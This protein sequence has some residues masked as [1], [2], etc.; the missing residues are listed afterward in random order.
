M[1]TER[2]QKVNFGQEGVNFLI[3]PL[4]SPA[5]SYVAPTSRVRMMPTDE[6]SRG[7][8]AQGLSQEIV[9]G[10]MAMQVSLK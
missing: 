3:D 4:L 9:A 1:I 7:K 10:C 2:I 8:N 6:R 5:P